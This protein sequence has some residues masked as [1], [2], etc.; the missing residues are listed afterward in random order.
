MEELHLV[1]LEMSELELPEE[2]YSCAIFA[3]QARQVSI[4]S[5]ETQYFT[6]EKCLQVKTCRLKPG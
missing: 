4:E 2:L 1:D 3:F 6:F 5:N